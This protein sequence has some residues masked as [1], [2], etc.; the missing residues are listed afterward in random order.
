VMRAASRSLAASR[1]GPLSLSP[2]PARERE[3]DAYAGV[4]PVGQCGAA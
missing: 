4:G 1:P 2:Y 3:W